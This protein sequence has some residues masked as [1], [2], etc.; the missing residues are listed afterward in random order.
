MIGEWTPLRR[1]RSF[2]GREGRAA[3]MGR[4]NYVVRGGWAPRRRAVEEV[5]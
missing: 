1:G 4:L 3:R 2:G 5:G